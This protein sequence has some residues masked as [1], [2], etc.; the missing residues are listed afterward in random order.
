MRQVAGHRQTVSR[1][2]LCLALSCLILSVGCQD[3]VEPALPIGVRGLPLDALCVARVEGVGDREIEGDYLA[4]VVTCENGA[5]DFE[6]LKAQA[7]AARSY[8][9]YKLET[10]GS[11]GDGQQDQVYS[12]RAEPRDIHYRAVAETAGEVLMYRNTVVAAFY[13]AGAIPSTPDCVPA[14]G[15]RDPTSTERWVTYNRGRSG[16]DV[17]QTPLG[18][19]DPRNL[20]NRGCNSQNGANCLSR[21]GRD[22]RDILRFYY[23]EDIG[24]VRAVGPCV[25]DP[26]QPDQGPQVDMAVVDAE[27]PAMCP[28]AGADRA[29]IFDDL[30]PCFARTCQSGDWWTPVDAG[31][32]EHAW[33]TGT[34]DTEADDC[35]GRWTVTV[36][37]PGTYAV[38]VH[39]PA[40]DAPLSHGA[41]YRVGHVGGV[42]E[43]VV[44][45]SAG[46]GWRL[47]GRFDFA[48]EGDHFVALGDATGEPYVRDGVRLVFDAVRLA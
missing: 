25:P 11:I 36:D 8:L 28:T 9:Y 38:S 13:V 4:H 29:A 47:L 5:A 32:A 2:R 20:R 34:L 12:C 31:Y 42:D 44:D 35:E 40:V 10:S 48:P 1:A 27:V 19:V 7:V 18:W 22:Y 16:D 26:G 14:A 45:Q 15:D 46:A 23:G 24:I 21:A 39:V 37:A 41:R 6:A 17:I 3:D 30:A 43:V 33:T